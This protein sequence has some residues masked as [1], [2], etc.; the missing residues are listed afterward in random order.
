MLK[1]VKPIP[2]YENFYEITNG[3]IVYS[4]NRPT[5]RIVK[6]FTTKRGKYL[7]IRLCKN[8][9]HK[10]YMVHRLV[11]QSFVGPCPVGHEGAHLNGIPNDN[12]IS[13]LRW[14]TK[15]ENMNHRN[16]HGTTAKG[17]QHGMRIHKGLVA[18]EKNGKSKLKKCDVIQI[19]E[20]SKKNITHKRISEMFEV[21]EPAIWKIVNH[22]TWRIIENER[23]KG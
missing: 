12:F 23:V 20:L 13:N 5:K 9:V 7:I 17:N 14:V 10:K 11:L 21:Q 19:L 8:G 15:K 2:D 22:R 1:L 3:G 18:G 16:I 4:I 6:P